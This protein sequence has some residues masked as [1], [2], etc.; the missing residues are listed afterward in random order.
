MH[1]YPLMLVFEKLKFSNIENNCLL[2][3]F[4][5]EIIFFSFVNLIN[6]SHFQFHRINT[7]AQILRFKIQL[8]LWDIPFVSQI[9]LKLVLM[10]C[11]RE[12]F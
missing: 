9:L 1:V 5:N 2:F 8:E 11:I 3:R 6:A 10:N 4:S 7:F 12:L